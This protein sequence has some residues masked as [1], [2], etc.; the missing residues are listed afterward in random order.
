MSHQ[1]VACIRCNWVSYAVTRDHAERQV[2]ELNEYFNTLGPKEKES[3]GNKPA[4]L[5]NYR[6]MFCSGSSFRPYDPAV[7][8]NIDGK[9]LNPVIYEETA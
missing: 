9:T 4:S 5:S 7:D 8:Y 3:F 6:C 1:A 2:K